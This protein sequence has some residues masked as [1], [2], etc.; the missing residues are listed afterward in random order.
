MH[1][2]PVPPT[3]RLGHLGAA[4]SSAEPQLVAAGQEHAI[5]LVERLEPFRMLPVGPLGNRKGL[6]LSHPQVM[7]QSL[8]PASRFGLH[9]GGGYDC[10]P[11]AGSAAQRRES[12]KNGDVPHL[13]FGPTHWNDE[14]ARCLQTNYSLVSNVPHTTGRPERTSQRPRAITSSIAPP[15]P[16]TTRSASAPATSRPLRFSNNKRAGLDV[17]AGST[18]SSGCPQSSSSLSAPAMAEGL[19]T[20]IPTTCPSPSNTGKQPPPSELTVTRSPG[21]P[22]SR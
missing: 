14:P 19:P 18:R 2:L 20:S 6:R 5:H 15:L 17:N 4:D 16:R 10:D 22:A 3:E 13:F 8:M 12:P 21:S 11:A 1:A 7:E 9:G